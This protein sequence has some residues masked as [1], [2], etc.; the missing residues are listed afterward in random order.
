MIMERHQ[1]D[2]LSLI[3]G[4]LFVTLA[5]VL[6]VSRWVDWNLAAWVLPLG[7]VLLGLG[8]GVTAITSQ[9]SRS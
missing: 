7:F 8:I 2:W 3:F 5:V 9:R 4:G 1:P 6:P